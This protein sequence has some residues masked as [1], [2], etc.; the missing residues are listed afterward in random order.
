MNSVSLWGADLAAA[1]ARAGLTQAQLAARAK[2]SQAAVSKAELATSHDAAGRPETLAKIA[3]SISADPAGGDA[4]RIAGIV[5]AYFNAQRHDIRAAPIVLDV[6][7]R[8]AARD[9]EA[10]VRYLCGVLFSAWTTT[11]TTPERLLMEALRLSAG[12]CTHGAALKAKTIIDH[13][14]S[15]R[16]VGAQETP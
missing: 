1:R 7:T 14:G 4:A 5:G 11:V 12:L 9:D 2:V 6:L 13:D 15:A 3:E 10:T 16:R 8:H